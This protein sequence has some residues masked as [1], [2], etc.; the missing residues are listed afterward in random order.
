VRVFAAVL[1]IVSLLIAYASYMPV[2]KVVAME[3]G[4]ALHYE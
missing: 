3:P 2:R 1:A 4:E